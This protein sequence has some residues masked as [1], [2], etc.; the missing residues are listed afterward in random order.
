M[1]KSF[2]LKNGFLVTTLPDE[3]QVEIFVVASDAD[4]RLVDD[5]LPL[6]QFD[7]ESAIDPDE[8]SRLDSDADRTFIVWKQPQNAVFDTNDQRLRFDVCSVG[9]V[10]VGSKL[11]FISQSDNISFPGKEFHNCQSSIDVLIR[12]LQ[13][14]IRHYLEHLKGIKQITGELQTK[15]NQSMENK[16]FLQM[17]GLSESLT[18]YINAIEANELVL[19]KLQALG[20]KSGFTEDQ[21]DFLENAVLDNKQCSRQAEIYSMVLAGL[22]DARGNIIN[23]NMT[24]LLKDLTIINIIFL[25]LNL[26]ASIGGM[27]EFS[28]FTKHL[29]WRVAYALFLLGMVALGWATWL[30]LTKVLKKR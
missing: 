6:D 13:T 5:K 8:V 1:Q 24:V 7:I 2:E 15:I 17:F 22:M 16:Y 30:F 25:P 28:A 20:R 10:L 26:I 29:D 21:M 27:S 9:I 19:T 4:K 14:T 11:S 3:G 18:Y 23:N 12:F